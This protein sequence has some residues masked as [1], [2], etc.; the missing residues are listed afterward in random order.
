[1]VVLEKISCYELLAMR[2]SAGSKWLFGLIVILAVSVVIVRSESI[3]TALGRIRGVRVDI[4][5]QHGAVR[6]YL[7]V[8]YAQPPVK[9]LR[10]VSPVN[11]CVTKTGC[12]VDVADR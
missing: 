11:R 2:M 3:S 10:F 1:M 12:I 6:A 5:G 7:G 4:D 9:S 8:P